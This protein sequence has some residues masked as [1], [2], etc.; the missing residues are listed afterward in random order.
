MQ[1]YVQVI[2]RNP[3]GF[4]LQMLWP[5]EIISLYH[6]KENN[7]P[8]SR[9]QLNV[10]ARQGKNQARFAHSAMA[11][12]RAFY[13]PHCRG[14]VPSVVV[15]LLTFFFLNFLYF[16][17]AKK[18]PSQTPKERLDRRLGWEK[19]QKER[20]YQEPSIPDKPIIT[21]Q[22]PDKMGL[23]PKVI[24]WMNEA[25]QEGVFSHLDEQ[26]HT[27]RT[28]MVNWCHLSLEAKQILLRCSMI[29]FKE[30]TGLEYV[31]ILSDQN[32]TKLASYSVWS[33][34]KIFW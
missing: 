29:Y 12:R 19:K 17:C 2:H 33:G 28:N 18:I 6:S 34:E 4:S 14:S 9:I 15:I 27:I 31:T 22:P 23:D 10:K 26:G 5:E 8:S 24:T 20:G 7:M 30:R 13:S 3:T 11:L 16:G 32:D 1:T 25:L 21:R